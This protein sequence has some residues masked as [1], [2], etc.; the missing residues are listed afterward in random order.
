MSSTREQLSKKT[1]EEVA[2]FMAGVSQG[3]PN[4]QAAK[5]EFML[6]QTKLQRETTQAAIDTALYTRRYTRYMF[7][8]VVILALSAVG[9]FI[10]SIIK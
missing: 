4:D 5:A 2:N 8:S 6:R 7:W 1:D 10:V 9:S 3:S